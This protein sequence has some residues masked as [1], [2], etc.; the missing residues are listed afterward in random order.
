MLPEL[1]ALKVLFYAE[2][3]SVVTSGHVTKMVV[4]PFNPQFLKN[5]DIRKLDGSIF[6]RTGIIAD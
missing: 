2:L 6:Y 1:H 3:V 4:T 5:P